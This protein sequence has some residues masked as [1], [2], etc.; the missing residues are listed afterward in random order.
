MPTALPGMSATQARAALQVQDRLLK[1]FPEVERVFGKA[2]RAETPTDPA[3]LSMFETVVTLQPE[4]EWRKGMTS[5]R[6]N[7]PMDP[8]IR[9]PAMPHIFWIPLMTR[10]PIPPPR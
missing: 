7:D 1:Q 4:S 6:L 10:T 8:P 2:G 5:G 9:F 3:P